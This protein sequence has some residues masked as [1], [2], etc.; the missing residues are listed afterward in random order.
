MISDL[1]SPDSFDTRRSP[2]P[3]SSAEAPSVEGGGGGEKTRKMKNRGSTGD[4]GKGA[5]FRFYR[6]YFPQASR[7]YFPFPSL[8]EKIKETSA[9][10]R[11]PTLICAG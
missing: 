4:D 6:F 5:R 2:T 10:G 7:A 3:L 1:Y 8:Y 11:G 9:E